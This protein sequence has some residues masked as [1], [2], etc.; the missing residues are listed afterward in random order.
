[1]PDSDEQQRT[2]TVSQA[3]WVLLERDAAQLAP[4]AK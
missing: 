1:M 2:A 4:S 3:V